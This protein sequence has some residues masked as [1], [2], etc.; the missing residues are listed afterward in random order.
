LAKLF[1]F[2]LHLH[3]HYLLNLPLSF[4]PFSK[5]YFFHSLN[6]YYSKNSHSIIYFSPFYLYLFSNL[7]FILTLMF[8]TSI[9]YSKIPT[10][11]LLFP[12]FFPFFQI[13]F[14]YT[15]SFL[16]KIIFFFYKKIKYNLYFFSSFIN[17]Y[18]F[19]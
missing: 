9:H 12:P 3:Y 10:L 2:P 11:L 7:H 16:K 15:F 19:K 1:N 5:I 8:I 17:N 4:L 14:F 6:Y 13:S 18:F